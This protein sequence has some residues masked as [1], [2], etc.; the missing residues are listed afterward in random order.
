METAAEQFVPKVHP[1]TRPVE[2]DDP[3][4]L[5]AT[6]VGGDPEVMLECL[7]REY[8]WMGWEAERILHLFQDPYY[9]A[10][11]GLL[12]L[13]GENGVRERVTAVLGSTGVFHFDGRV[14]DGPES[15]EPELIELGV[16]AHW[17]PVDVR[18]TT[19]YWEE[20]APS[21]P[22]GQEGNSHA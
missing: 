3:M 9:P 18:A 13:F 17:Q 16:P 19:P 14:H 2:P 1:A 11:H 6:A 10:L 21:Q 7:V 4:T 5:H 20:R 22:I 15:S 12:L 8:A